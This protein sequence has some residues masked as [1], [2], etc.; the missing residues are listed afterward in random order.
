MNLRFLSIVL[1]AL[2]PAIS[3]ADI[4]LKS[5][6][7]GKPLKVPADLIATPAAKEF[8]STGKNSYTDNA[9][10]IKAGKKIFQLY[11]CTACHGAKGE[12]AVGPNL[13]DDRWNYPK[14]TTDQGI[15]ETIWG[16]T[17]AG[18]GAKGK[19]VML[20]DDPSEGL[21]PDELLKVIAF[22]RSNATK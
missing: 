1:V 12:G 5:T 4:S 21:T 15:F 11:S 7:D 2:L 14:N 22:L 20:P 10:A 6:I 16:G 8:F 9:D 19:G 3:H 13:I 18:M 17:A